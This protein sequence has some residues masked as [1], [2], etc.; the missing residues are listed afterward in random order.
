MNSFQ[1]FVALIK[2]SLL[3]NSPNP[4]SSTYFTQF[5]YLIYSLS[6]SSIMPSVFPVSVKF[7]K[8]YFLIIYAIY[9]NCLFVIV[10][11]RFC[12]N[13]LKPCYSHFQFMVCSLSFCREILLHS[14]Q[15]R[16]TGIPQ[17][18]RN[19]YFVSN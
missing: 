5:R 7:S 10:N 13:S 15:C 1:S 14:L 9:F 12:Y 6:P 19:V 8:Q 2:G 17:Q 4:C 16:R 11:V 18:F 3:A